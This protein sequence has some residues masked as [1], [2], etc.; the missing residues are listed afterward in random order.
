MN[1]KTLHQIKVW[2]GWVVSIILGTLAVSSWIQA[3][4]NKNTLDISMLQK[5]FGI[6]QSEHILYR[7]TVTNQLSSQA[8]DLK[9]ITTSVNDLAVNIAGIRGALDSIGVRAP[10]QI[11]L[12]NT[13]ANGN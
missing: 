1:E 6:M 5:D 4:S 8:T 2:G 11:K 7:D 9:T 12:N 10:K 3:F 13:Q